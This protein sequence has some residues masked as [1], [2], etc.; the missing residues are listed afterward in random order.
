MI[1][2]M[3]VICKYNTSTQ[4]VICHVWNIILEFFPLLQ[5]KHF[6]LEFV[7]YFNDRMFGCVSPFILEFKDALAS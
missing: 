6:L 2:V 4:C 1:A 3:W 5:E 7:K